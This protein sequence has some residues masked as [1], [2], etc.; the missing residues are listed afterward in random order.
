MDARFYTQVYF[1]VHAYL[2][3]HNPAYFPIAYLEIDVLAYNMKDY[4][5]NAAQTNCKE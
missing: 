4:R 5:K 3:L 1:V 2:L